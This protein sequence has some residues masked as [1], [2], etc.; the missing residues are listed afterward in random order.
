MLRMMMNKK[1]EQRGVIVSQQSSA[2][3]NNKQACRSTSSI[4]VRRPPRA[5][6]SHARRRPLA[7]KY[8]DDE[9]EY[10]VRESAL[11]PPGPPWT[12]PR[13]N[14][15]KNPTSRSALGPPPSSNAC[16]HAHTSAPAHP[17]PEARTARP[18][19]FP[20]RVP[21]FSLR[22]RSSLAFAALC[23]WWW[24]FS[25]RPHAL[26]AFSHHPRTQHVILPPDIAKIMPQGRL[27]TEAEWR[28]IGVQ[29]SRG[30]CVRVCVLP[31]A[32]HGATSRLGAL[33]DS[34][35]RAAHHALQASHQ[36]CRRAERRGQQV[37]ACRPCAIPC[38]VVAPVAKDCEYIAKAR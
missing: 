8:M 34:Q 19:F 11:P 28:G 18:P 6:L 27:L 2:Q 17:L 31:L 33:R 22:V 25:N 36:L 14:N 3:T 21:S 9:Y 20:L 13:R 7:D 1:S 35:A 38:K 12:R 10:R 15:S 29:Q 4:L 32:P 37:G 5:S 16:P 30:A 26:P 24:L 23:G